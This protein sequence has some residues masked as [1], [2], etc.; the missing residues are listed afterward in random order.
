MNSVAERAISCHKVVRRCAFT[1]ETRSEHELLRFVADAEGVIHFDLKRKLPGRGVW[2]TASKPVLAEAVKR[3][4]FNRSL[5]RNMQVPADLPDRVED[6]LRR[7]AVNRLSL[8]NKA[9]QAAMGFAKVSQ[10]IDKGRV[11]ALIHAEEAAP[12]GCRRLDR[13]FAARR[14]ERSDRDEP[15]FRLPLEALSRALGRENVNHAAALEGGAGVSFIAAATRL[16]HFTGAGIARAG[17]PRLDETAAGDHE[18]A[19]QDVE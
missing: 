12:D 17:A 1:R 9:G 19:K 4:A 18:P 3:K 6:A 16:C 7:D 14:S 15:V 2:I 10:A 5:R 13:K 11:I 8:A